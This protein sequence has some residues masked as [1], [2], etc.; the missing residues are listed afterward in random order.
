KMDEKENVDWKELYESP[1]KKH[2][3]RDI[4]EAISK[5]RSNFV[6]KEIE[7]DIK[8]IDFNPNKKAGISPGSPVEIHL[9][10]SEPIKDLF[11]KD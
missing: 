5:C 1:I 11:K 2:S 7:T 9:I 6:G 8:F 10:V 4:E 3:T